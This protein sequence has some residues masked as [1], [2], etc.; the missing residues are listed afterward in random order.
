VRA[1]YDLEEQQGPLMGIYSSLLQ[2]ASRVNFVVACDVPILDLRVLRQLLSFSED[3]DIAVPSF[4][5]GTVEPLFGVYGKSVL[6]AAGRAL[7]EGRRRIAELFTQCSTRILRLE[8]AGWYSNV[9]SPEDYERVI[10]GK[11]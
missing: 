3:Y 5:D 2:S 1:V 8:N 10:A 6:E 4:E 9:N 7:G 11:S